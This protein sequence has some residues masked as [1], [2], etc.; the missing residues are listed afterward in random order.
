MF[1]ITKQKHEHDKLRFVTVN[2]WQ[3]KGYAPASSYYNESTKLKSSKSSA[4]CRET[5]QLIEFFGYS[6]LLDTDFWSIIPIRWSSTRYTDCRFS[7]HVSGCEVYLTFYRNGVA[8]NNST[9]SSN[10]SP[11]AW[12]L[13]AVLHFHDT[14]DLPWSLVPRSA[15]GESLAAII[16]YDFRPRVTGLKVL[17]SI[18][19]VLVWQVLFGVGWFCGF[20]CW[21]CSIYF[22]S[23][24]Q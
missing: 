20:W 8:V 14:I 9:Y 12:A 10:V 17:A 22:L 1:I 11:E 3:S 5:Q 7:V 18:F 23:W 24:L 19:I 13:K 16:S 2:V 15:S 6:G 4:K 21:C